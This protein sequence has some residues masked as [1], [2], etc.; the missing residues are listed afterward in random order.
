MTDDECFL[1]CFPVTYGVAPTSQMSRK[2]VLR[3]T[4]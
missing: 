4:K 3:K 1:A 2:F